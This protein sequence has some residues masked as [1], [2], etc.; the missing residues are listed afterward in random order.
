M[1][2]KVSERFID[3]RQGTEGK[4]IAVAL[5][6]LLAVSSFTP[7]ALA[8][9][10]EMESATVSDKTVEVS[11]PAADIEGAPDAVQTL[12]VTVEAEHA[13][14]LADGQAV[15]GAFSAAAD[16]DL[17]IGVRV[18]EGYVLETVAYNDEALEATGTQR[19]IATEGAAA[20]TETTTVLY[21]VAADQ[22]TDGA[23]LK[24]TA[25]PEAAD[26]GTAEGAPEQAPAASAG[27]V[28]AAPAAT[29]GSAVQ[30]A[31]AQGVTNVANNAVQKVQTP[32]MLV[33]ENEA[34]LVP[35]LLWQGSSNLG[36]RTVGVP[37]TGDEVSI[38]RVPPVAE[39]VFNF[40]NA[41]YVLNGIV[42]VVTADPTADAVKAA[43]EA[44]QTAGA[45]VAALRVADGAVQYQT[46]AAGWKTLG[47][48]EQLVHFCSK[49]QN[50]GESKDLLNVAVAEDVLDGAVEGGH[51]VQVY[52]FD[53]AAREE[54]Q[55]KLLSSLELNFGPEVTS[56]TQGVTFDRGD[57]VQYE[58]KSSYIS[59]D[60]DHPGAYTADEAFA[61]P[62]NSSADQYAGAAI[63]WP[64]GTHRAIA[65]FATPRSY[66]ASYD[67]NGAAGTA[68]ASFT[69]P[70]GSVQKLAND[71]GI[72]KEGCYL[73]AWRAYDVAGNELDIYEPAGSFTMPARDVVLKAQWME[74]DGEAFFVARFV[75]ADENGRETEVDRRNVT[76]VNGKKVTMTTA[77]S[78]EG[79]PCPR[80]YHYTAS[81]KETTV[82]T[83][84]RVIT[85]YCEP[86]KYKVQTNVYC[87]GSLY[88]TG[89][90]DVAYGT[91]YTP[92]PEP[93][94][95]REN[96]NY[97]F[98]AANPAN[99]LSVE[100]TD[101][102]AANVVNLY[103][104]RD[105]MGVNDPATGDGIPDK[106]QA[107]VTFLPDT[108]NSTWADG[109]SDA[110]KFAVVNRYDA[111]GNLSTSGTGHLAAEQI[112][113]LEPKADGLVM[114]AACGWPTDATA[115]TGDVEFQA[116]FVV[117]NFPYT[118]RYVADDG[119]VLDETTAEAGFETAIPYD[120]D[121]KFEGYAL[122]Y[123]E[124]QNGVV[125]SKGAANV[126][127]LHYGVDRTGV[128]NLAESDGIPDKY[129]ATVVY[130]VENGTFTTPVTGTE[131][132]TVVTLVRNEAGAWKPL[133]DD[134]LALPTLGSAAVFGYDEN[135][136]VWS[137][138][139][140]AATLQGGAVN[141]FVFTC[142]PNKR[143][144]TVFY[145]T[146]SA[147]N[148]AYEVDLVRDG[149]FGTEIPW[150]EAKRPVR[151]FNAEPIISGQR[152]VTNNSEA[153]VMHVVF[154]REV[155][156]VRGVFAEGSHGVIRGNASQEVAFK[157]KAEPM[158]FRADEGYRI[159]SVVVNG[160]SQPVD[161]G[162]TVYEFTSKS[163]EQNTNIVVTTAHM[164]EIVIEAPSRAKTYDGAALTPG[165]VR[166]SGVPEGFTVEAAATGTRTNAG[167]SPSTVDKAS[168]KVLDAA[169]NDVTANFSLTIIDGTLTVNPAR[170]I[171]NVND[172]Q[173]PVG[174]DD[175]AFTGQVLGLVKG[176]VLEG[177]TYTRSIAGELA[178]VYVDA[179]TADFEYN[180]NYTVTVV[181]GTFTI[182]QTAS[183]V[184]GFGQT[185]LP[186]GPTGGS[187]SGSIETIYRTA[188]LAPVVA[189]TDELPEPVYAEVVFDDSVLMVTRAGETIEDDATALGAFDEPKCWVHWLMALGVLL[190]LG[191]AGIVVARRLGYARKVNELDDHLMGGQVV[192]GEQTPTTAHRMGA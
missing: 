35:T 79:V 14:V 133:T 11:R 37:L 122:D 22:L 108:E 44:C 159:A 140:S 25:A 170:A 20:G 114:D 71:N 153:N 62:Q 55:M 9:A 177:L 80:G 183:L 97:V 141:E 186:E 91:V 1:D 102:P 75:Y 112:P 135:P 50:A 31:I 77:V 166:I 178:G 121:A 136:G 61:F 128:A 154:T 118:V 82:N 59:N 115:I 131:Y 161:N 86:T 94:V 81:N 48:D 54:G 147:S 168:V 18:A 33:T 72:A 162:Q 45:N 26:D 145:H 119:T 68:P 6:A 13:T 29:V 138:E 57:G 69:A 23:V 152:T 52:V 67:L 78:T 158:T 42:G 117:G 43:Y 182:G 105:M 107:K 40:G 41:S 129:Q 103:Y 90:G 51:T 116:H 191:Y 10:D 65:V 53:E 104:S 113:G 187:Q 181:P 30:D 164:D 125:T 188:A 189:G 4:A 111:D 38:D 127:T 2:M 132:T 36:T 144:Y 192:E 165:D 34:A 139:P 169:R 15:E 126:V 21:T 93:T 24:V 110:E 137:G 130:R 134:E 95:T 155:Y 148:L 88:R 56:L 39:P 99:K 156:T 172:A 92:V 16:A 32:L 157:R 70:V 46:P 167:V 96:V 100:V 47:A 19:A 76:E 184:P 98:D 171:V 124:N 17:Q 176:D 174:T 142:M 58:V 12:T 160:E 173:K 109:S 66:T 185:T 106:Y 163:V 83:I 190:T 63:G 175:P 7:S 3:A 150:S 179:L 28:D 74:Y 146:D 101:D 27:K 84:G 73:E 5:T 149:L 60:S 123:V 120:A 143:A 89:L 64:T 8:V 85:F 49:L 151:G 180:P 87:D